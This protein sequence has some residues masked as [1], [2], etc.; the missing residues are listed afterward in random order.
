MTKLGQAYL[1]DEGSLTP[2]C[3]E[4]MSPCQPQWGVQPKNLR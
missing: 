2:L 1:Q 4:E 3:R